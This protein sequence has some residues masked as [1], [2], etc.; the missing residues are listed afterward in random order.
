MAR[1]TNRRSALRAIA[2][3]AAGLVATKQLTVAATVNC[4]LP[5]ESC[6]DGNLCCGNAVCVLGT[7]CAR[8]GETCSGV[9]SNCC[10]GECDVVGTGLCTP[11]TS[12]IEEGRSCGGDP[13]RDCCDGL[14]CNESVCVSPDTCTAEGVGCSSD[15]DCC[16]PLICRILCSQPD[17]GDSG[18]GCAGDGDCCGFLTCVDGTCQETCSIF[19]C[20]TTDDCCAGYNCFQSNFCSQLCGLHGESCDEISGCCDIADSCR[21]GV[22][23]AIGPCR[24]LGAS[25]EFDDDCC[26]DPGDF[27]RCLDGTCQEPECRPQFANCVENDQCCSNNCLGFAC[28]DPCGDAGDACQIEQG[29]SVAGAVFTCCNAGLACLD[30]V[31]TAIAECAETGDPCNDNLPCCLVGDV[32][33]DG[34]CVSTCGDADDDCESDDDCCDDLVCNDGVCM[35]SAVGCQSDGGCGPCEAC[36]DNVCVFTCDTGETCDED[37][38]ECVAV[39]PADCQSDGDCGPCEVCADGDCVSVCAD[40]KICDTYSGY[41]VVDPDHNGGSGS[42][43]TPKPTGGTTSLPT[44][45]TGAASEDENTW[46]LLALAGAATAL[47][48]GKKLS[49]K[50][51][52]SN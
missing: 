52:K 29:A 26:N 7:C 15:R 14:I 32:C 17:C 1:S 46:S 36:S 43:P 30:G 3:F 48:T 8:D 47:L 16:D 50:S 6:G 27:N 49:S 42:S 40:D 22:C 11:D 41:C 39:S 45:G 13:N 33:G 2:G 23:T 18:A 38:G 51:G 31:C 12:C 4:P 9:A 44:T 28:V 24:E 10:S 5:G 35:G 34:I 25:C 37:T 19:D 21:D 20:T